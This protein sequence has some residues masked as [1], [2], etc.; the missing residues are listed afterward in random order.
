MKIMEEER[1]EVRSLTRNTSGVKGR[2]R[3]PRCGLGGM[4]SESII[5]TNLYKPNNKLINA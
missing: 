3:A 1:I 2:A 4:T 5:H